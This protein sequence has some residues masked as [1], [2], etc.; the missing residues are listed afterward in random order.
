MSNSQTP[1]GAEKVNFKMFKLAVEGP[2]TELK[3]LLQE[4]KEVSIVMCM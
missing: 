3:K 4:N 1:P 2:T